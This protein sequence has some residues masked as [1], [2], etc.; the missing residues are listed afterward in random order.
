[1]H[2]GAH[3][4]REAPADDHHAVIVHPHGQLATQVASFVLPAFGCAIDAAPGSHEALDLRGGGSQGHIEQRGL[5]VGPGHAREC[6]HLGI[7]E[8]SALHAPR[9]PR[10]RRQR[11]GHAHFL[12]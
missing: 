5:I 3:F 4:R 7:G 12:A 2:H 9:D 1:L 6:A 10:Q 8:L 11:P